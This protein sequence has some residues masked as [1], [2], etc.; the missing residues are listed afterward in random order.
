MNYCFLELVL[1]IYFNVSVENVFALV[2]W[3]IAAAFVLDCLKNNLW[4]CT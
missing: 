3:T 4:K 2:V 1:G